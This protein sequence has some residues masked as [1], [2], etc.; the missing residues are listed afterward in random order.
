MGLVK[1]IDKIKSEIADIG[2]KAMTGKTIEEQIEEVIF[3][4]LNFIMGGK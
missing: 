4:K 1:T 2:S 3:R